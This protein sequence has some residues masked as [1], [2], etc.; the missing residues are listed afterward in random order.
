M[1]EARLFAILLPLGV[2]L[3]QSGATPH[4]HEARVAASGLVTIA[5][6]TLVFAASGFAFMFGGVGTVLNLPDLSQYVT[7][8][9][10]PVNA[11][12]WGI[13]G[14]RGFLLN[15]VNET[16]ALQLFVTFL[17]LAITCAM[18]PVIFT[19]TKTG[20]VTQVALTLLLAGFLFPLVGFWVWGGGW[21]ANLG[22]NLNLGHGVVDLGGLTTAALTA[23]GA[24]VAV[25]IFLPQSAEAADVSL[26][27]TYSPFRSV[28]G[29]FSALIGSA[30]IAAG[31]PLL[32]AA[33]ERI[34]SAVLL[35]GGIAMSS[36]VLIALLY[37]VSTVRKP[38]LAAAARA[39]I[40]ALIIV[41]AGNVL[42]PAWVA[43]VAGVLAGLLSTGGLYVINRRLRLPNDGG[44]ISSVL[45]PGV[46]GMLLLGLFANGT[47]G[48]GI[49]QI[50]TT[51]YLG[52][53]NL[54]V[55]GLITQTGA[56][57]DT[58]QLS[59]QLVGAILVPAL[60]FGIGAPFAWLLSR[61]PHAQSALE[62]MQEQSEVLPEVRPVQPRALPTPA[63]PG[64]VSAA[65]YAT[66]PAERIQP[67]V[68]TQPAISARNQPQ[69]AESITVYA[70]TAQPAE[71]SV[72]NVAPEA[73]SIDVAQPTPR[74]ETL[75]ERLRRARNR[76]QEPERT[77]Q[78]R[79]VAYPNRVAGR[80]LS[81]RPM[82]RPD[83]SNNAENGNPAR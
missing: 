57:G 7:Y 44:L 65:E 63:V 82:T 20:I 28:I 10:L 4:N 53:A 46:L 31:N 16:S 47:A 45:I 34:A 55:T 74:K 12:N 60:A 49:N 14:L 37:T 58:G 77:V 24:G 48:Q 66:V 8:Y 62:Q 5:L 70:E 33:G 22:L 43:L 27:V 9:M 3:M 21:L 2:W 36:A 41:S 81:I 56:P 71:M 80:P 25:L 76:N 50:G 40:G 54:G 29:L 6:A 69:P 51:T 18:L 73:A 15:G 83:D 75:L 13:I 78:P 19:L 67:L 59:A 64:T 52:I 61:I 42:L 1:W 26:P 39:A 32:G 38:D 68:E 79:H 11:Q 72:E 35:N 30:A 23:G 17:P